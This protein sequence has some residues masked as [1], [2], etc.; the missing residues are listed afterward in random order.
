MEHVIRQCL[1]A[2]RLS[3]RLG[4]DEAERGVVYYGGLLAWVGCH[5]DAYEQ[6]KWFG[7]DIAL[8]RDH[9]LVD[10]P[11]IPQLVSSIGAGR[12]LF[13]RLRTGVAFITGGMRD[14][15]VMIENHWLATEA[16]AVRLG[17]G[18][19]VRTTLAE[20]F[21]RW[22]GKNTPLGLKGE[23]IHPTSRLVNLADVVEVYHR[24]DG[25]EAAVAVAR[26]R[27]GSQFDPALV[28]VFCDEAPLLFSDLDAATGWDAVLA[29]EPALETVMSEEQFDDAL[30]AIA[31][32]TDLKSPYVM[33]HSRGVAD[34][35]ADAGRGYGLPAGDVATLRRAGLVHDFGRLGVSNAVWDK[36]GELSH[37]EVERVRL[38]P[39][40]SERMLAFSPVLRPLGAIAVQ[41]HERM[42]G[43]GYPRGIAGDE[44]TP[45]G[46]ILAAA[47]VYHAMTELR[48]H[49]PARSPDEAAVELRAEVR[50]KRL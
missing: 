46:R 19:Q 30:E 21:E 5:V 39:Y 3:E 8:K 48:P 4:F 9:R 2:L 32:F 36:K 10:R 16:L 44:I 41:H 12:P 42:D 26:E 20:S 18:E 31:D 17:L 35:A 50:D 24:A 27:A 15:M 49:R 43:S 28:D 14:A 1:I 23:E 22:D 47:D 34:L 37:A 11:G 33:G 45:A 25:V 40:L 7:D 6:A 38:H 13:D 29:A